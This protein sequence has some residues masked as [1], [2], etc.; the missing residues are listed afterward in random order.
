MKCILVS[1]DSTMRSNLSVGMP[2]DLL[3]L[4]RDALKVGARHRFE[5][6]DTYFTGLSKEWRAGVREVFG[7]LPAVPAERS[8]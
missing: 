2:I 7:R 1:F 4:E 5:Q 6:H 8:R 3:C